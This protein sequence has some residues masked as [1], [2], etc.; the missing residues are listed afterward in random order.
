MVTCPTNVKP[1]QKI[2]FQLPVQL[3]EQQLSTFK[4]NYD[5]DGWMRCLG[6]DLKFHWVYNTI[7]T[8]TDTLDISN[9][10][11]TNNTTTT[12]ATTAT[13]GI[14]SSNSHTNL[15]T[16]VTYHIPFD[17]EGTAFVRKLSTDKSDISF[18]PATEYSIGMY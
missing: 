4:V 7:S 12:T 16:K 1:G 5:K 2:R 13:N 6:I 8:P 11:S 10:N 17:L 3:S 18:I 9:N 15:P 14:H